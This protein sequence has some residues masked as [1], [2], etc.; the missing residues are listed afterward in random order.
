M[1]P[2]I[3]R[4]RESRDNGSLNFKAGLERMDIISHLPILNTYTGNMFTLG[5]FSL[6]SDRWANAM[7]GLE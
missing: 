3:S 4:L 1:H 6:Y 5:E 2:R 7:K